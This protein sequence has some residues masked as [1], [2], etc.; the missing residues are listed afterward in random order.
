MPLPETVQRLPQKEQLKVLFSLL[1]IHRV[2]YYLIV[3]ECRLL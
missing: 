3:L 1:I 2:N